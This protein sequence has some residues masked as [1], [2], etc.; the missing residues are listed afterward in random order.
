MT[1][2]LQ[3]LDAAGNKLRS[4][5]VHKVSRPVEYTQKLIALTQLPGVHT[6]IYRNV[7]FKETAER[8]AKKAVVWVARGAVRT[9]WQTPDGMAPVKE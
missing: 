5:I 6:I 9:K 2:T 4:V 3:A 1:F 7:N 8:K